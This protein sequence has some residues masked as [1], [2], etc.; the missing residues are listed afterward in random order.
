VH[1]SFLHLH[2][3]MCTYGKAIAVHGECTKQPRHQIETRIR[4]RCQRSPKPGPPC[5]T[6]TH[7]SNLDTLPSRKG[8]S[9]PACRDSGISLPTYKVVYVSPAMYLLA[10]M[11]TKS[12]IAGSL[13]LGASKVVRNQSYSGLLSCWDTEQRFYN[14]AGVYLGGAYSKL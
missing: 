2:N 6:P 14:I 12:M 5:A 11:C 7:D 4:T 1:I 3:N 9:C 8:G 13:W 10:N